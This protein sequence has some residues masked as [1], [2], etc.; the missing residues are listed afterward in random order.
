MGEVDRFGSSARYG[1]CF[2]RRRYKDTT[3]PNS[4]KLKVDI[5]YEYLIY[6]H[7]ILLYYIERGKG[8]NVQVP[9]SSVKSHIPFDQ[10]RSPVGPLG[11]PLTFLGSII[12][13]PPG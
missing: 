8:N 10:S 3:N 4:L 2:V 7:N 11:R 5:S 1:T 13:V 9:Q 12:G 6:H